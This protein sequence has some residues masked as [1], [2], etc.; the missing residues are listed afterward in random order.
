MCFGLLLGTSDGRLS[1]SASDKGGGSFGRGALVAQVSE[2][3]WLCLTTR[4]WGGGVSFG[5]NK[6][7]SLLLG[8]LGSV[9]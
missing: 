2:K 8:A 3:C 7:S 6:C 1:H 5:S 4:I 9:L